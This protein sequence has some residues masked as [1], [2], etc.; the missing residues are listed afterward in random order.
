MTRVSFLCAAISAALLVGCNSSNQDSNAS[1]ELATYNYSTKAVYT[2]MQDTGSYE[3]APQ[4]FY[5]VYTQLVARHGSRALSSPKYDVLTKQVW[6]AA[7]DQGALTPLG[8]TLGH[9]VDL[10]TA[11]NTQLGYGLLTELGKEEHATLAHDL[12]QRLPQLFSSDTQPCV[13]VQTSGKERANESAYYFMSSLQQS[14]NYIADDASC[15]LTQNTPSDIDSSL[16]NKNELY[17]H[18]TEPSG[19][20]QQYLTAFEAYQAF[21]GDED[22][23]IAAAPELQQALDELKQLPM[24]KVMARQMLERIYT[25]EF[26]DYLENGVEFVAVK[27][28]DGGTTYVRNEVDAALMLYNLFIIGPGMVREAEAQGE[29]WDLERYITPEESDWFSYLSDAEDFYEK[30]PSFQNQTVTYDIAQAL[31]DDMFNE[32]QTQV[33]ENQRSHV[34]KLRFSHAE[35]IIP[36][37]ALM[38]VQGSRQGAEIGTLY[39]PDNNEWRGGWVSPYAANIQWDTY[40]ND[41]HQVLVKLLYNEKEIAFKQGCQPV[42]QGSYYYDFDEL[43]R[44]YNY[45]Q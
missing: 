42:T 13:Q 41:D 15:Y 3:A 12:A 28:E 16:V 1:A 30:G 10:V 25:P 4:G 26:V 17:F 7:F 45:A 11:A 32:V 43:K 2:T 39:H 19:D 8:E 24:T 36:L 31:L 22:E 38:Q 5:P 18:K 40:Q 23:G 6:Q 44:C 33:V 20:Y 34:A 9:K 14:V 21:I 29:S 35:A 27:P 37:A